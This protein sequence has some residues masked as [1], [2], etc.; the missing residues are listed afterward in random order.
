MEP[1]AT[2]ASWEGDRL[3]VWSKSQYVLNEQAELAAIFGLPANKVLVVCPFVGG[4][5]GTSLRTWSHVSIAALASRMVGRPI[6]LA[7]TRRQMFFDTGHRPRTDQRVALAAQADGKLTAVAHEATAETSRYEEFVEGITNQ[8]EFLYSCPNVRTRYRLVPTDTSTPTYMRAPG[9]CTG[10]HALECALDELAVALKIDPIELRRRNEPTVDESNG[11]PF[12]SRS[13]LQCLEIGAERF[14]WSRRDPR[15][16]S[17]RDGRLQIGWGVAGST[18]GAP[19]VPA[20]A[21]VRLLPNGR[22]EV[23]SATSDMGPGTYTS[24]AQVAA[25]TLGIPLE[26]VT[27]RLGRSDMPTAPS[28]GGSWTMASVGNAVRKACLAAQEAAMRRAVEDPASVFYGL[29]IDALEWQDGTLGRKD[30]EGMRL[31]QVALLRDGAPLEVRT[32][33][34]RPADVA[35]RYSMYGYAAYFAEVAVDPDLTLVK[36]RRLVGV[37][38][39]GKI[40]NPRLARS[41]CIGGM[42]GG[43]GMALMERTVLD[44]RDGRPVNAHMADYLVP[45]NLDIGSLETHFLDERDDAVNPLGVKGIGELCIIGVAPAIANAVYHATGKRIRELPIRI[46]SLLDV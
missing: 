31:N 21:S 6:K 42:V 16:G 7:L 32:A 2:I 19:Q 14:G 3:T 33:A 34:S 45:V 43:I 27:F 11:R 36:V 25:G 38:G 4:A 30:G 5:F 9:E 22:V 12:S 41:Q 24:M 35:N 15:P 20:E 44:P 8:S 1:H 28:H 17:M 13:L 39:I 10:M 23:E 26:R 18:R 37:Y 40:V 29:A 46:E